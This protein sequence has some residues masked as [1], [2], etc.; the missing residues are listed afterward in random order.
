M[1][2]LLPIGCYGRI[3]PRSGWAV[4]HSID[5]GGGVIDRDYEGTIKVILFNHADEDFEIKRGYRIAQFVAEKIHDYQDV[6]TT[7]I[8]G[9]MIDQIREDRLE[10]INQWKRKANG[11][12]STGN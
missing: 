1:K 2:V 12:G 3:A 9:D 11:F 10:E 4:N 6:G 7:G 5:V 8:V